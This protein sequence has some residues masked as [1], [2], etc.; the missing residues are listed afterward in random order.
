[1]KFSAQKKWIHC[2]Q[3]KIYDDCRHQMYV[4]EIIPLGISISFIGENALNG[5]L[6]PLDLSNFYKSDQLIKSCTFLVSSS[7]ISR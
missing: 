7:A 6:R 3:D 5:I 1:M 2:A 4:R